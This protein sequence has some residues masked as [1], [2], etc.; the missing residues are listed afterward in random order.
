[1]ITKEE[2]EEEGVPKLQIDVGQF[3]IRG[4][5]PLLVEKLLHIGAGQG[6]A[7]ADLAHVDGP[8]LFAE[9]GGDVVLKLVRLDGGVALLEQVEDDVV[10]AL[11]QLAGSELADQALVAVR[12]L[13]GGDHGERGGILILEGEG[14]SG[15]AVAAAVGEEQGADGEPLDQENS[16]A[17][18]QCGSAGDG[19]AA[20]PDREGGRGAGGSRR[21]LEEKAHGRL[22][23]AGREG[24]SQANLSVHVD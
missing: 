21:R 7:V 23:R 2:E 4:L 8:Q 6:A 9:G 24:K 15:A 22:E 19:G 10:S 20:T 1:M 13:D 12:G 5:A 17:K 11:G 16:A 14:G 3:A 18:G